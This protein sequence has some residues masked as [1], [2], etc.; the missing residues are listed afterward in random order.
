MSNEPAKLSKESDSLRWFNMAEK[1]IWKQLKI[2]CSWFL[3]QFKKSDPEFRFKIIIEILIIGGIGYF[4]IY[5]WREE[6]TLEAEILRNQTER[7]FIKI[8]GHPKESEIATF[9]FSNESDWKLINPKATFGYIVLNETSSGFISDSKPLPEIRKGQPIKLGMNW[10]TNQSQHFVVFAKLERYGESK[11]VATRMNLV[12]FDTNTSWEIY[13][14]LSNIDTKK[15][16]S[17]NREYIF[18]KLI[19][20]GFPLIKEEKKWRRF[21]YT[22]QVLLPSLRPLFSLDLQVHL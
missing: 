14:D 1:W 7:V 13:S 19:P 16:Y 11:P 22:K 2:L 12:P 9:I 10:P 5:P 3:N 21:S 18:Q 17:E 20:L 4:L 15:T 6:K 8:E